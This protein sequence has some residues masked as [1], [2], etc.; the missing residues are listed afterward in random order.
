M[1]LTIL[2][3]NLLSSLQTHSLIVWLAVKITIKLTDLLRN[4][5]RASLQV[6][7]FKH[8]K[9]EAKHNDLKQP[10]LNDGNNHK[11]HFPMLAV[12]QLLLTK[13]NEEN[14]KYCMCH[15]TTA[16]KCSE[17]IELL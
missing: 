8:Y 12:M 16:K 2:S 6:S 11:F 14:F 17:N 9:C 10:F 5:Q 13:A 15:T 1:S 7:H 3:N 4:N